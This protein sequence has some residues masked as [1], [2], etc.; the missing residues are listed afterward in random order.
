MILEENRL[1]SRE[2]VD[3]QCT[4][5]RS[6]GRTTLDSGLT[7]FVMTHCK[8]LAHAAVRQR[9]MSL[10]AYQSQSQQWQG[11]SCLRRPQPARPRSTL[12]YMLPR[13]AVRAAG[14]CCPA[15]RCPLRSSRIGAATRRPRLWSSAA[16]AVSASGS[17]P[18]VAQ[19][20]LGW[21]FTGGAV[22]AA[23][24]LANHVC[25]N[26]VFCQLAVELAQRDPRVAAAAGGAVSAKWWYDATPDTCSP[27]SQ[28]CIHT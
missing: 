13:H 23:C 27:A 20:S 16:A 1:L 17:K 26:P 3:A 14:Q 10:L 11:A 7:N 28:S 22:A 24:G 2:R 5:G 19:R 18:S 21:L 25:D 4:R 12:G 15:A 9:V 6:G 8:L